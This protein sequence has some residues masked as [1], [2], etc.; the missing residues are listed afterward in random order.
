MALVFFQLAFKTFEEGK[1][2]SGGASETG[3]DLTVIETTDFFR[4]AFHDG[5]A[6]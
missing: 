1:C 3:N 4:V 5:V 6:K 2:I